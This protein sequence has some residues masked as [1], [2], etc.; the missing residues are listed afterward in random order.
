[1]A[2][3]VSELYEFWL[4]NAH[5][6]AVKRANECE[7]ALVGLNPEGPYAA[8]I[9]GMMEAHRDA[10]Y[11]YKSRLVAASIAKQEAR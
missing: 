9:R 4:G 1:M 2:L 7:R 10:A 5:K 3:K 8:A 11:V 6:D